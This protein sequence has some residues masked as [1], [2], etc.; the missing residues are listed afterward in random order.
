MAK[1]KY[2][3]SG[4]EFLK[5]VED[6]AKK[7]L[8]DKEISLSLGLAPAY[9]SCKKEAVSKLSDVLTRARA[10]INSVV[11][12]KYLALG[13]GGLKTKAVTRRKVEDSKGELIDDIIIQETETELPPNLN[14]LH[15]WL[16]HH[17]EEWRQ[18]VIDGKK[19]DVTSNGETVGTQLIFASTPLSD[20]DIEDIKNIQN[21]KQKDSTDTGISEA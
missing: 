10:Q 9:F 5:T 19:L 1:P 6:L 17:D 14:A 21:G 16:F 7:G 18:K 3:Y 8:T 2:N 12:Q 20:K 13:L 15:T 4:E 11:R